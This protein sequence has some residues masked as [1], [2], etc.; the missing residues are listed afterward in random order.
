[1]RCEQ[2][3]IRVAR[4]VDDRRREHGVLERGLDDRAL[5]DRLA[6]ISRA[7]LRVEAPSAEKNT[8]RWHAR[9]LGRRTS[10]QV[11]TPASSS[12]DPPG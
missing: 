5:G 3:E 9:A 7:R 2:V 11:A 6:R 10:R 12:I 1:M 8:N 4:G